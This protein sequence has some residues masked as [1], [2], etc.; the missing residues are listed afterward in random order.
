[1]KGRLWRVI[2]VLII[3]NFAVEILYGTYMVF[4]VIGGRRWPLFAQAAQTPIE[5]IMKRRLYAVETWI[6][7]TGLAVYVAVTEILPRKTRKWL[8]DG[9][10]TGSG[11]ALTPLPGPET[12]AG[13]EE[14][15]G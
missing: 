8:R 6:A 5:V 14:E 9:R 10:W 15:A 12:P 13:A 3:L 11:I 2:H 1:M 4:M 7:M